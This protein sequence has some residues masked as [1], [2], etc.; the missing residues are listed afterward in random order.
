[1]APQTPTRVSGLF[2]DTL[3]ICDTRSW[4]SIIRGDD[5]ASRCLVDKVTWYKQ[6]S[7]VQHEFLQFI[8]WSEDGRHASIVL[9]EPGMFRV[10]SD[11]RQE[12]VAQPGTISTASA[13]PPASASPTTADIDG[14]IDTV[15]AATFGS[16]AATGLVVKCSGAT[17]LRTLTF[18]VGSTRPS[19]HELATLLVVTSDNKSR[20]NVMGS[21]CC[22]FAETAFEALKRLFPDAREDIQ[23]RRTVTGYDAPIPI[24]DRVDAV[25][26]AYR[27]RNTFLVEEANRDGELSKR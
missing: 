4:E 25:C 3:A 6:S 27:K 5:N 18:P 7:T 12:S 11:R 26:T 16:G 9:A 1:M 10:K 19:A 23:S 24:A 21:Q 15:Y 13:T 2:Q 14:A 20:Y 8:I 22:G 17:T